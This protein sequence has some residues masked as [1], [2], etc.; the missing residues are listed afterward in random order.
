M[1]TAPGLEPASRP[2]IPP[3]A[4]RATRLCCAKGDGT[5]PPSAGAVSLERP[6]VPRQITAA[7]PTLGGRPFREPP[8]RLS[9]AEGFI[10]GLRAVL[11]CFL[12]LAPGDLGLTLHLLG[13]AFGFQLFRTDHLAHA[14][15]DLADGLVGVAA[16]LV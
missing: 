4:R 15:L 16:S 3:V 9:V 14:L 7:K 12:C 11:R 6:L 1:I 5:P 13:S 10:D 8:Q 2:N